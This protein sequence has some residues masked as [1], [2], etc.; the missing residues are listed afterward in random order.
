MDLR[1]G[2]RV[3]KLPFLLVGEDD[4]T[5][6]LPVDLPVLQEDL[7]PEVVDD[8]GVGRRVWLHD[9]SRKYKNISD[10]MFYLH[11]TSLSN[12][13]VSLFTL[14]HAEKVLF[15][16]ITKVRKG[17]QENISVIGAALF[18][19]STSMTLLSSP[20]CSNMIPAVSRDGRHDSCY[21][22]ERLSS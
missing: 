22:S 5:Q 16:E 21:L 14:L 20:H 2:D 4:L 9:F 6:L 1:V 13:L 7:W 18:S 15:I 8:A 12:T 10:S 11:L 17:G 19:S 3:Q